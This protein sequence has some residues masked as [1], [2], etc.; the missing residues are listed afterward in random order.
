MKKIKTLLPP[1]DIVAKY[2]EY[3]N[4]I[5]KIFNI[6]ACSKTNIK[7][8]TNIQKDGLMSTIGDSVEKI[9]R[10]IRA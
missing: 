9:K 5:N 6:E 7:S 4:K 8:I 3:C 2:K 1:H 10:R